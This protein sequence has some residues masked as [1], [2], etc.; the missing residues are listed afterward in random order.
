MRFQL[1]RVSAH[2]FVIDWIEIEPGNPRQ[3][4]QDGMTLLRACRDG[5]T[6]RTVSEDSAFYRP[7][8]SGTEREDEQ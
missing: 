1:Q 4:E 7:I 3:T 2:G 6:V 8:V 5:E